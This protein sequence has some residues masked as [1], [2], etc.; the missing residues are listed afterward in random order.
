M[1]DNLSLP[2]FQVFNEVASHGSM[3]AAA[4]A[5]GSSASN[6]AYALDALEAR[7][8]LELFDRSGYRLVLS[9]AGI[10]LLPRVRVLLRE[11]NAV[12]AEARGLVQGVESALSLIYDGLYPVERLT[13]VLARFEAE[14]PNVRLQLRVEPVLAAESIMR[15][16]GEELGLMV[17]FTTHDPDLVIV[18]QPAVTLVAVAAP[19][20]PLATMDTP[21]GPDAL[22]DQLQLVMGNAGAEASDSPDRGVLSLRTWRMNDLDTKHRL[23]RAGLGWGSLPQHRAAADIAQNRLTAL[24]LSQWGSADRMPSL[25]ACLAYRRNIPRGP[26]ARWLIAALEQSDAAT[27]T[28]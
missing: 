7:L 19:T 9:Q 13:P 4:T 23:L 8:G 11:A 27:D 1:S 3:A 6:V 15:A 22:R 18:P 5:L 14:F 20:H 25:S 24:H 21:L 28:D 26:A 10:S 12:Q 16:G 2:Q 17:D